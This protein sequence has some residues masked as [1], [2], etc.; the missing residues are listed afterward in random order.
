[1]IA[2]P[3]KKKTYNNQVKKSFANRGMQ[4]EDAINQ[5][6]EYYLENNKAVV[7][8]KPTPIKVVKIDYQSKTKITQAFFQKP[9]TTDY[10]GV[11]KGR[12]ID[13][14]AKETQSKTSFSLNNI[15]EHQIIHLN[16]VIKQQGIAFLIIS[17]TKYEE[18]YF[19]DAKIVI[20]YYYNE[21][22]KSIPYDFIKKEGHLIN[23]GFIPSVDYLK[24]IEELYFK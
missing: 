13:F 3:N 5:T 11:Y 21:K 8:K 14:E 16:K 22:R 18:I 24:V 23:N 17:F 12:Y 4:L 19:I 10:N 20:N 6:N 15:S 7:H 1:M 2:Y 9:S